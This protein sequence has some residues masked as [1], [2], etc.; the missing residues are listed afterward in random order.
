MVIEVIRKK[1][2]QKS[3]P[4]LD[5]YFDS[6]NKRFHDFSMLLDK[7]KERGDDFGPDTPLVL[8]FL[9][10]V[11]PFKG[12]ANSTTRSIIENPKEKQLFKFQIEEMVAMLN[13]IINQI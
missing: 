9:E 3:S 13:K 4:N 2:P 12:K 8:K 5:I 1:Y 11:K 10:K 7:L 6:K